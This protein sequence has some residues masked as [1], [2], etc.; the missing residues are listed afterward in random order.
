MY[1]SEDVLR[2]RKFKKLIEMEYEGFRKEYNLK[3]IDVEV[4]AY[5]AKN[6]GST[7]CMISKNLDLHKGQLSESLRHLA[8][9]KFIRERQDKEDH[10]YVHYE[11]T[12]KA[13]PLENKVMDCRSQI[14]EKIWKGFT[15]EELQETRRLLGKLYGNIEDLLGQYE[16]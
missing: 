8:S 1:S 13:Q 12:P 9:L 14:H 11:L 10:R 6:Q 2:G 15:D 3:Q 16:A 7:A 5:L 4:L